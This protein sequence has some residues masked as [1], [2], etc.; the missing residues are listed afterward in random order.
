MDMKMR[1]YDYVMQWIYIPN[2]ESSETGLL[3][4]SVLRA[5]ILEL[6]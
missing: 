1:E 3:F 2:A 6:S 4:A 5:L